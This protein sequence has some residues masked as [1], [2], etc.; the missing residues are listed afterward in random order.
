MLALFF[1]VSPKPD[2]MLEYLDIAAKLKPELDAVGGCL[3]IER[4]RSLQNEGRILSF[5]IWRDEAAMTAWRVHGTHHKAQTLGRTQIFADYR[6]R[7]A[8]VIREE[9]PGKPAWQAQRLNTYN[10]PAHT[11]PRHMMCVQSTAAAFDAEGAAQVESFASIYREGEFMHVLDVPSIA[12][13]L[14]I[15]ENCRIGAPAYCYRLC[16][17]ERDYSMHNRKEAP[18]F[19]PP[20]R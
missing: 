13:G 16:E 19:Y 4:F 8:Q 3:F 1:E 11:P 5:Q 17:V 6:L 2:R 18:Q 9:E 7:V 15:S 20:L 10:D 12:V 14:D